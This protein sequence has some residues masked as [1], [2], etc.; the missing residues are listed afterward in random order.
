MAVNPLYTA[1]AH[2]SG[3]KEFPKL[4]P[5]V[6]RAVG[7]KFQGTVKEVSD[8]FQMDETFGEG[9]E[10]VT[11]KVTKQV[12]TLT[13]VTVINKSLNDDGDVSESTLKLDEA[14]FWISKPAQFT[15][16]GE[17]LG[18]AG[19]DEIPV[20]GTMQFKRITDGEAKQLKSGKMGSKPHRFFAKFA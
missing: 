6:I 10:K 15:A 12:V 2:K 14:N 16:I 9:A 7:D 19:Y 13:N 17:A 3:G 4:P 5:V 11:R 18:E 20:G 1:A 8:S